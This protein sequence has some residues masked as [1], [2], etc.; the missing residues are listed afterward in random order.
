MIQL[1]SDEDRNGYIS[2][3]SNEDREEGPYPDPLTSMPGNFSA[4]IIPFNF[5]AEVI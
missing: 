4:I 2:L 3:R 1:L 5:T